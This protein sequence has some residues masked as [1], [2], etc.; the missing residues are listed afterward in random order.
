MKISSISV[1]IKLAITRSCTQNSPA[2]QGLMY[3]KTHSDAKNALKV[4]YCRTYYNYY[5]FKNETQ[6]DVDIA[7]K[8][9]QQNVKQSNSVQNYFKPHQKLGF[10]KDEYEQYLVVKDLIV[11]PENNSDKKIGIS[12]Y[13]YARIDQE[14]RGITEEKKGYDSL[15]VI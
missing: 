14:I 8:S 12:F 4:D 5:P 15:K 1:P 3:E 6:E 10:T 7:M 13:K 2:F 9:I 11:N